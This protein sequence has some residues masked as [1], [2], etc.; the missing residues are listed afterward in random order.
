MGVQ[1]WLY[2]CSEQVT[3]VF[4]GEL[5]LPQ[6]LKPKKPILGG[7]PQNAKVVV[8]P[9][10]PTGTSPWWNSSPGAHQWQ[11]CGVRAVVLSCPLPAA[12]FPSTVLA[13]PPGQC[14]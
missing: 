14:F 2:D 8:P 6:S 1:V 11:A 9:W 13:D 4:L 12:I 5:L 7:K 3:V 10:V